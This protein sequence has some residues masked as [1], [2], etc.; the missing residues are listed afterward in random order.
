MCNSQEIFGKKSRESGLCTFNCTFAFAAAFYI[1]VSAPPP[2]NFGRASP[3]FFLWTYSAVAVKSASPEEF[4]AVSIESCRLVI[5]GGFVLGLLYYIIGLDLLSVF[6]C[7][8]VI[9]DLIF[10][11]F[12]DDI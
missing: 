6:L 9:D 11:V 8:A 12:H 4:M 7:A 5:G 10:R 3:F 1:S 2:R